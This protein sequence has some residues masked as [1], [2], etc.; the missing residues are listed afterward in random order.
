MSIKNIKK[1]NSDKISLE[2][3]NEDISISNAIRR[4]LISKIPTYAFSDIDISINTTSLHNDF[5]KHRIEL[6]PLKYANE[7]EDITFSLKD[8][9]D[10]ILKDTTTKMLKSSNGKKYFDEDILLI[11]LKHNQ[12]IE[13]TAKA[14][15]NIG[16]F[17][18]KHNPVSNVA[19]EHIIDP[20][21]MAKV[22]KNDPSYENKIQ[23]QVLEDKNGNKAVKL[24]IE[25]IGM[26][27]VEELFNKAIDV[28]IEKL[29]FLEKSIKDENPEKIQII[30][31]N[32][33]ENTND[34]I[35]YNEDHTMGNLI[36]NHLQKNSKCSF[37]GYKKP[38]PLEDKI[39][40]RI[41]GNKVKPNDVLIE[42]INQVKNIYIKL[43]KEYS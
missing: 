28:I 25:S 35:I 36:V 7:L 3:H 37:A 24:T 10:G 8:E 1:L 16:S 15:K 19:M 41:T 34:Y 13:F 4:T 31:F 6:I 26:F 20:I 14:S 9:T 32:P 12:E 29:N 5:I 17:H 30:Q 40:I 2:I 42:T 21:K 27:P 23:R 22:D 33:I 38:H 43:N 11:V 18:S 39:I